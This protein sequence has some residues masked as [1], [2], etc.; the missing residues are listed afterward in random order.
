MQKG[1]RKGR[2]SVVGG[3]GIMEPDTYSVHWIVCLKRYVVG[4]VRTYFGMAVEDP[5]LCYCS[6]YCDVTTT[7]TRDSQKSSL[8]KDVSPFSSS[9]T[10]AFH[11]C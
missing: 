7:L 3:S 2:E 10:T 5:I 1:K 4:V 11:F 6:I 9:C 8:A